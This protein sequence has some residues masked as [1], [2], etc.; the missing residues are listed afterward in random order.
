MDWME[1]FSKVMLEMLKE[2]GSMALWGWGFYL[3]YCL[4]RIV[5]IGG[6]IWVVC[7][8]LTMGCI[9]VIGQLHRTKSKRISLLSSKVSETLDSRLRLLGTQ[10]ESVGEYLKGLETRLSKLEDSSEKSDTQSE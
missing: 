3:L 1:E 4:L 8:C 7:T 2:G 9:Q 5:F 10:V 6:L